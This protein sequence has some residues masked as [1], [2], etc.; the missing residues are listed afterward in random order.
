M[1]FLYAIF[2][3]RMPITKMFESNK[4]HKHV[5]WGKS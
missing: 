5:L 2:I 1:D 3:D 4:Q